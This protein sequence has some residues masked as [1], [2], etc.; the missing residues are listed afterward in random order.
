MNTQES[1]TYR[2]RVLTAKRLRE[3]IRRRRTRPVPES[4][5]EYLRHRVP[6]I[7]DPDA[8]HIGEILSDIV[9]AVRADMEKAGIRPGNGYTSAANRSSGKPAQ[10]LNARERSNVIEFAALLA[11]TADA[12]MLVLL[13]S[14]RRDVPEK[15][16]RE[17]VIEL[18]GEATAWG[19]IADDPPQLGICLLILANQLN[20]LANK[21]DEAENVLNTGIAMLGDEGDREKRRVRLYLLYVLAGIFKVRGAFDRADDVARKCEELAA[22]DPDPVTRGMRIAAL[23]LRTTIA[24]KRKRYPIALKLGREALRW[25]DPAFDPLTHCK[26][27]QSLGILYNIMEHREEGLQMLLNAIA[28]L[29]EYGLAATGKWVYISAA[30][31]YIKSRE[32]VRG[33]E[34]LDRLEKVLGYDREYLPEDPDL[35]LLH[36]RAVR[37]N[38]LFMEQEYGTAREL[39]EWCIRKYHAVNSQTG[40]MASY[41]MIAS[42]CGEQGNPEEACR[43][44][45]RAIGVSENSSILNRL[46]LRLYLAR[47][48][49]D[50]NSEDEAERLLQEIEPDLRDEKTF[51]IQL[52]RLRA[53]LRERGGDL[54]ETLR[55]EREAT[56]IERELQ[57]SNRER[58]VRYARILAETNLLEQSVEQEREQRQRL[59]HELAGAMIELGEKRRII[60]EA[61]TRLKEELAGNAG[62]KQGSL[63]E[64]LGVGGIHSLLSMLRKGET[65]LPS[66]LAYLGNAEDDFVQRLRVAY[67]TLIRSQERLCILLRSG[68]NA[69][70]IRTLLGIGSEGLKA[71]RKRLRKALGAARG[72]SLEKMLAEV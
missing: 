6:E 32:I 56:Q 13:S 53:T 8:P 27:L 49:I 30:E 65:E 1:Q 69:G 54:P 29:E 22:S 9:E 62:R 21:S 36:I 50:C 20:L 67:P 38:L 52:L 71:R 26:V 60:E 12:L 45:E 70:E 4:L 31:H 46:R 55:L 35:V 39:L 33:H 48:K 61:T 44:L 3:L 11:W 2:D 64:T 10:R 15:F 43:Y 7:H 42:I 68:L 58:S 57:E 14:G 47:W 25:S 37:A 17:K 66:R 41:A 19:E 63:S 16:S 18:A 51:H 28:I 72:E 34:L 24:Q 23:A 40:A 59:E 5:G